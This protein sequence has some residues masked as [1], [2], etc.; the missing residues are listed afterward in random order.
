MVPGI[1]ERSSGELLKRS[2]AGPSVHLIG[3]IGR[4]RVEGD[5]RDAGIGAR[6]VSVGEP[7]SITRIAKGRGP[8][9]W[10]VLVGVRIVRGGLRR[11][12]CPRRGLGEHGVIVRDVEVP[13][14]SP[15]RAPAIAH[16]E[17]AVPRGSARCAAKCSAAEGVV[18]SHHYHRVVEPG[19]AV[20]VVGRRSRVVVRTV[21]A[22]CHTHAA[23]GHDGT[24]DDI[25]V[26]RAPPGRVPE[27]SLEV[28]DR[29]QVL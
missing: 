17:G 7:R 26:E 23:V 4:G 20:V 12:E 8:P 28:L 2:Q 10:V 22:H 21:K 29:G 15:A 14:I 6:R 13:V 19:G 9:E 3:G 25:V 18:P 11:G 27:S 1:G 16:D 24:L 5:R